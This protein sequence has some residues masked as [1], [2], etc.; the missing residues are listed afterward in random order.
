VW[1]FILVPTS[2]DGR[3]VGLMPSVLARQLGTDVIGAVRVVAVTEQGIDDPTAHISG[4]ARLISERTGGGRTSELQ[5]GF[6]DWELTGPQRRDGHQAAFGSAT[7]FTPFS[8]TNA[9]VNIVVVNFDQTSASRVVVGAHSST[10]FDGEERSRSAFGIDVPARGAAMA[11]LPLHASF[12]DRQVVSMITESGSRN[13]VA[14]ATVVDEDTNDTRIVF[15]YPTEY[16]FHN[17]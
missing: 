3:Q 10:N 14:F 6:T 12:Y 7:V 4:F 17:R 16:V 9:R 2:A 15:D 5:P 8:S 11:P 1:G 13:W